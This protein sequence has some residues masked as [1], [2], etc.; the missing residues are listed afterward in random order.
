MGMEIVYICSGF[1]LGV[2][3]ALIRLKYSARIDRRKSMGRDILQLVES[4]KDIIYYY[5]MKPEC[6]YRYLSP[7]IDRFLGEGT[8]EESYRNPL[9]SYEKIHPDDYQIFHNKMNGTF[10]YSKPAIQ[11]WRSQNEL[12]RW[13]E[14]Y[15]TPI[16][17]NDELVAIQGIIRNIDEKVALQQDLEYR[18]TH[19]ALTSI[20]SRG[21][22]EKKMEEYDRSVDVPTGVILCDL[23]DL[24]S[25]NDRYGHKKGDEYIKV[26]AKLLS[27]FFP[28]E[29]TVARLGGDE[30]A[31]IVPGINRIELL[32]LCDRLF[33]NIDEYNSVVCDLPIHMSVGYA[34]QECSIGHMDALL[35]EADRSMYAHSN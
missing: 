26:S 6:R 18:I 3:V 8:M 31:V 11:R 28:E 27:E 7:S 25:L 33:I 35:A 21:Y 5:E 17:E 4:S 13:F 16:Y 14:E 1:L 24:K 29:A 15:A 10:D 32:K 34:H 9:I 23:D 12:Y 22:F 20:Y 30:F 19:D 2:F